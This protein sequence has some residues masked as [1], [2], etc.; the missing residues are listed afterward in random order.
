MVKFKLDRENE[1]V[2]QRYVEACRGTVLKVR[3]MINPEFC[4]VVRK[5]KELKTYEPI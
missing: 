2:T 1:Q 5:T 4:K 3:S